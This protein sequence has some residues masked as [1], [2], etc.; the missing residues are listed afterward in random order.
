MSSV[1]VV[2]WLAGCG[3]GSGGD[4]G[5]ANPPP[6]TS[7]V[8]LTAQ[9]RASLV[10]TLLDLESRLMDSGQAQAARAA[11]GAALALQSGAKM[12][13][14]TTTGMPLRA[15]ALQTAA[16]V[17]ATRAVGYQLEI[18]NMVGRA[19]PLTLHGALAWLPPGTIALTGSEST[20]GA[21]PPAFGVLAKGTS[22]IWIATAGRVS[23]TLVADTGA[24]PVAIPIAGVTSCSL[25]TFRAGFDL[26][27]YTPAP[28]PGN[29]ATEAQAASLVAGPDLR[30]VNVTIDCAQATGLV[31]KL[32]CNWVSQPRLT[33]EVT[34]AGS[35]SATPAG[36]ACNSP[37][38]PCSWTFPT[39]T[40]VALKATGFGPNFFFDGGFL[41]DDWTIQSYLKGNGGTALGAQQPTG[42]DPGA[43]RRVTLT[44]NDSPTPAAPGVNSSVYSF[45][46]KS[47]AVYAPSA[48]GAIATLDF[49][50]DARSVLRTQALSLVV[51]Q[52][53]EVY[54]TTLEFAESS[55]WTRFAH[56]G[57]DATGFAQL[58]PDLSTMLANRPDFSERGSPIQFGFMRANSTADGGPGYTTTGDVD[59][60][61]VIVRPVGSSTSPGDWT[62]CPDPSATTNTC[63]VNLVQDTTVRVAFP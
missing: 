26:T 40:R 34:G 51:K 22:Q 31:G 50:Q 11:H 21:I 5:N 59:N 10:A 12:T 23:S 39:G 3:G 35:V 58:V 61:L 15:G 55:A 53:G 16:V 29:T 54:T 46:W 30:G 4:G 60:W 63:Y 24:C 45:H 13:A 18:R 19:A 20:E 8:D 32:F 52:G 48:S 57:I 25:A 38:G 27:A 56:S 7:D 43:L 33:V 9:D 62:S 44:M 42:G 17:G 2:L 1:V 6:S 14:V 47:G 49:S 28:F 37:A 41:N 36:Q